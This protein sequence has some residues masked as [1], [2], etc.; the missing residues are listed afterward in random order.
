MQH[1]QAHKKGSSSAPQGCAGDVLGRTKDHGTRLPNMYPSTLGEIKAETQADPTLSVLCTFVAHGWHSDKSQVPT[2]LRHYYL[3]R[4]ELAVYHGVLYKS[5]K[6]L[7]PV[8]L[9]STMLKK[10]QH[11][12]QGGESMILRAR[13][14]FIGLECK[15]LSFTENARVRFLFTS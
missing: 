15:L 8:K 1:P 14:V 13:E 9:Q 2:A 10:L 12:H 4:D 6:V 5:H 7:I 11:G 3:L